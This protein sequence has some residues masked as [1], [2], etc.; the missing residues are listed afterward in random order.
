MEVLAIFAGRLVFGLLP[1]ELLVFPAPLL[2]L[3]AG[4]A[5]FNR[6]LAHVS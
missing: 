6:D 1:P 4:S 2:G 5:T 3:S